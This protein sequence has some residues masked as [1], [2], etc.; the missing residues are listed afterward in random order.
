MKCFDFTIDQHMAQI[1]LNLVLSCSMVILSAVILPLMPFASSKVPDRAAFNSPWLALLG[2]PAL[3]WASVGVCTIGVC[4]RL[5]P[6]NCNKNNTSM[7]EVPAPNFY[8][9]FQVLRLSSL[10]ALCRFRLRDYSCL[11]YY[12]ECSSETL[13][14]QCS[15]PFWSCDST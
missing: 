9:L 15:I 1:S 11:A 14:V 13:H 12:S 5:I 10:G 8:T 3:I 2:F 6:F 7:T 4:A